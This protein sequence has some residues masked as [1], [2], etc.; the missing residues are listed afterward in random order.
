M[1][2]DAQVASIEFPAE[3]FQVVRRTS[4]SRDKYEVHMQDC[5]MKEMR[6]NNPNIQI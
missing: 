1:L 6:A 4:N 3:A 2:G 5:V